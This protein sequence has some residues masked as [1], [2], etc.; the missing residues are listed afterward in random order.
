MARVLVIEDDPE[1][2]G[3]IVA[4]LTRHGLS[5]DCERTGLAGLERAASGDYDV[6]TLDRLLPEIDG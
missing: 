1:T 4:E 6:I 2:A 5:V 3:E